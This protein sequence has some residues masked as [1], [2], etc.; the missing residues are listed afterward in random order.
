MAEEELNNNEKKP[1]EIKRLARKREKKEKLEEIDKKIKILVETGKAVF[2]T[3]ESMKV[4]LTGEPKL[5]IYAKN[6]DK[7]KK[8][9]IKKLAELANIKAIEYRG[10]SMSL[11]KVCGKL[12][13]VSILVAIDLGEADFS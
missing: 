3:N 6:I 8:E 1:E 5:V 9:E 2:G 13:P 10:S 11:G 7:E 4:L 12:F